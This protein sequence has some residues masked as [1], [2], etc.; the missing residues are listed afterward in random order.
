V[1][2][3]LHLRL[4]QP[5]TVLSALG[6]VVSLLGIPA[7]EWLGGSV[8]L[9][10]C[11][12]ADDADVL[13]ALL[14]P[15]IPP[16]ERTG[17]LRLRHRDGRVRIARFLAR[18]AAVEGQVGRLELQLQ[19]VKS[20]FRSRP[21][22][23]LGDALRT[24]LETTDD[25]VFFKDENHVFV[26]A[27]ASLLRFAPTLTL[28]GL[29]DY[30]VFPEALADAYFRLE[31]AVFAGARVAHAVQKGVDRAGRVVWADNHKY[32]VEDDSGRLSGLYGVAR[33]ITAQVQAETS[34]REQEARLRT[35]TE[36]MSD[37]L[38]VLTAEGQVLFANQRA[39]Q[40]LAGAG[41]EQV[42]GR[43]IADLVPA[44]EA[45]AF[46]A[47]YQ[48]TLAGGVPRTS[49]VA[50]TLADGRQHWFLNRL[51]P[52]QFGAEQQPA[53]LSM[54]LD[55]SERKRL[56]QELAAR[57]GNFRA[58]AE[59]SPFLFVRYDR[60]LRRTYVSQTVQALLDRDDSSLLGQAPG[61]QWLLST[62]PADAAAYEQRLREALVHG[63]P[64]EA[65]QTVITPGG[66]EA[67]YQV[68]VVPE[69]DASGA[70]AS[71]LVMA[72]DISALKR[73]ERALRHERDQQ[74]NLLDTI[75]VMVVVLQPDGRIS[76]VNRKACEVLGYA[77]HELVGQDWFA[78]CLPEEP[79]PDTVRAV[80]R[81][82]MAGDLVGAAYHENPVRTRSGEL[83]LIAWHNNRVRDA[84][85]QVIGA[86]GSGEDIT[87]RRR[88]E[89]ERDQAMDQLERV[90][91]RV[92][93]L[94]YEVRG[95]PDGR[96]RLLS[97]NDMVLP[98]F[99][100]SPE[101]AVA[102]PGIESL[103]RAVLPEDLPGFT[104]SVL[105]AFKAGE[106]WA[107]QWRIRDVRG[108]LRWLSGQS[109]RML[110][111]DPDGSS[112]WHG[113]VTDITEQKRLEEQLG[114]ALD[115]LERVTRSIPG[116]VYETRVWPDGRM[117][118]LF[119]NG[120][121]EE[122]F[123]MSPARAL[124]EDGMQPLLD[125]ILPEDLEGFLESVKAVFDGRE[126]WRHQWRSR[127]PAGRIRWLSGD[128]LRRPGEE[129][130]GSSVWY[131]VVT[132]V[133]DQRRLDER[134]R[135]AAQVFA[136]T[137][138]SI[139]VTDI[140]ANICEV[141]PAFETTTGYSRAEVLGKNPRLLK[142]G[143]HDPAFYQ[144]MWAELLARGE[145]SGEIWNRRKDSTLFA[146][147]ITISAI[148]DAAGQVQR[149]VA[150]SSDVTA[151]KRY[152]EQLERLAHFDPLTGLPNRVLLS[153][154]LHQAI[155]AAQ[156]HGR[157]LAV[158]Y[159]DLDGFKP[160]N[161]RHGHDVG[162]QLLRALA[163]RLRSVVRE[164]DTVGRIGG[165]EFVGVL[166]DLASLE[167]AVPVFRRMLAEAM[168]PVVIGEL[169]LQVSASV[170]VAYYEG[171][172]EVDADQL[173][174]QAD[175]AM[176]QAKLAGKNRFHIFDYE[177]D[178]SVRH[179]QESLDRIAR[180]LEQGEFELFYQP[181]VN[182]RSR[183]MLGVEALIRW[184][185]PEQGLLP[186]AAF[187]PVLEHDPLAERM[188]DWVLVTALRQ[189]QT[190]QAEGLRT[191][192]SVNVS[193]RHLQ[194]HGFIERL[195]RHLA[196]Y[197]ELP[198]GSLE[199]EVLE[200]SAIED[201]AQVARLVEECRALGVRFALDD[202]GTGYSSL[203]YLRR[204]G[205]AQ[206]KI[207]QTFVRGMLDD[208]EDRAI[209]EAVRGLAQAFRREVLAEGVETGAQCELLLQL[210]I[211]HAQGFA[212]G[213]PMPAPELA[214]WLNQ[215]QQEQV[216][217]ALLTMGPAT[218]P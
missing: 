198:P 153:D 184:H 133:T 120:Q 171:A 141:N 167:S 6:E 60:D 88:L 155:A 122:W 82:V 12:H 57:E 162:D 121:V 116:V 63:E 136:N 188:G 168:R 111:D 86:L 143:R 207:D 211:D 115:L 178:R 160:V 62:D 181:K 103:V 197:P 84:A 97:A 177:H 101:Q 152:Q 45:K 71:V 54:S 18:Y 94:I 148:R 145:W 4:T 154:R 21:L 93:A 17:T 29:T 118:F 191:C 8:T 195:R 125:A 48:A 70:V 36:S 20:L 22:P 203:A 213:Y 90:T 19:E 58:L 66:A 35:I 194:Q 157:R 209:L 68:H 3:L 192:V 106:T 100:V 7:A 183:E 102:E 129:A 134:A 163:G 10:A 202:F 113:V 32:R 87:E 179:R 44:A 37:T 144:A 5:V 112:V 14:T 50:V 151:V 47:N 174:R 149:Y 98:W 51:N 77:A 41:P 28:V 91:S 53:V 172:P 117:R 24:V 15:D 200:S 83:R 114:T 16:R 110:A 139:M 49:E 161:D 92:P 204:L 89:R 201:L 185:H 9:D 158:V 170:G 26:G 55:I 109:V 11:I 59:H 75:E 130:D 182:L 169:S 135:L 218:P 33:D 69:R 138:E 126:V 165:D 30:D 186:P 31:K 147:R 215:W 124:A 74:R 43:N 78:T 166:P 127:D 150:V 206:I 56:E 23:L 119:V 46:I 140:D 193:A 146:E 123:G 180:A 199:L 38:T 175:Q 196:E 104:E 176:Y 216:G 52:V 173:L 13:A 25:Y 67:T 96:M 164:V 72:Q 205:V 65:V 142:S 61:Q 210:G 34:L 217:L 27:S 1:E 79:D 131:G 212:I 39:A 76:Q 95:W 108:H 42:V 156:R 2:V 40:N 189:L 85:G 132:D 128:S 214:G 107:H 159:L 208:P 73:A 137:R 81:Q 99:G 187:L 80:F 190:W 64:I 105:R